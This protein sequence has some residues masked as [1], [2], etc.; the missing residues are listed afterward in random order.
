MFRILLAILCC[1]SA[2]DSQSH[3]HAIKLIAPLTN[4]RKYSSRRPNAGSK[5][6]A[7]PKAK[8]CRFDCFFRRLDEVFEHLRGGGDNQTEVKA[9]DGTGEEVKAEPAELDPQLKRQLEFYFSDSNLPRDKF[10]LHLTQKTPEGWVSL[11]TISEFKKMRDMGATVRASEPYA[12]LTRLLHASYTPLT[13]LL[14]ASYTPA[15]ANILS[16]SVLQFLKA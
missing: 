7:I 3:G 13:R 6:L 11:E 4:E 15:A 9:D 2:L 1:A 8:L 5:V 14:H 16:V 10:L 12:P